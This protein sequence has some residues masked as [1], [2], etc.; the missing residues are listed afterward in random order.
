MGWI[1]GIDYFALYIYVYTHVDTLS[2]KQRSV[3]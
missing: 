1:V 3:L 2:Y